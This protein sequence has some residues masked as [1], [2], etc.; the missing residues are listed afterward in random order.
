MRHVTYVIFIFSLIF[1]GKDLLGKAE[2]ITTNQIKP[3][4]IHKTLFWNNNG[5]IEPI[6][7]PVYRTQLILFS[8]E[9]DPECPPQKA[10]S[11]IVD[12]LMYQWTAPIGK[13]CKIDFK[14]GDEIENK[15]YNFYVKEFESEN[16]DT[17]Y[18]CNICPIK[19]DSRKDATEHVTQKHLAYRPIPMDIIKKQDQKEEHCIGTYLARE[20]PFS[21]PMIE[22]MN[23]DTNKS[24]KEK[25]RNGIIKHYI[26]TCK[27]S[28]IA[29]LCNIPS[30][31]KPATLSFIFPESA[32]LLNNISLDQTTYDKITLGMGPDGILYVYAMRDEKNTN[33]SQ[34]QEA[35]EKKAQKYAKIFKELPEK[36]HQLQ[37]LTI[38]LLQEII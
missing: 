5:N 7:N 33:T 17:Y 2:A 3:T 31:Y 16:I 28:K 22:I 4:R 20:C 19:F 12:S 18:K 8:E 36:K 32:A 21:Y 9:K 30:I 34:N 15:I 35:I 37:V 38:W 27:Y 29:K 11:E 1:N 10:M 25:I 6:I 23:T 14:T 26:S 24:K 13:K